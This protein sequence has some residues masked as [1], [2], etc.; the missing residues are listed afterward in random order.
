MVSIWNVELESKQVGL[1]RS[2]CSHCMHHDAVTSVKLT[3]VHQTMFTRT[4]Q[5]VVNACKTRLG[6]YWQHIYIHDWPSSTFPTCTLEQ[7]SCCLGKISKG[8]LTSCQF[9][10]HY[11]AACMLSAVPISYNLVTV[12]HSNLTRF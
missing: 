11:S 8:G 12:L 7:A 9:T 1:R 2:N 4:P 3:K 5:S 10:L 6:D